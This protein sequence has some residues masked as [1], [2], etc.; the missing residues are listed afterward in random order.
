M[1]RRDHI[2]APV[3]SF[4]NSLRIELFDPVHHNNY[5]LQILLK[6]SLLLVKGIETF[7]L[8]LSLRLLVHNLDEGG[9]VFI[10]K[11]HLLDLYHCLIFIGLLAQ[12]A[13]KFRH[14]HLFA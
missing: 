14:V 8:H 5:L 3:E 9:H 13:L 11:L 7:R 6:L 2:T 1:S 10:Y 4:V 12:L